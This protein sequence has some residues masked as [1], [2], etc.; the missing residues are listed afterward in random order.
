MPPDLKMFVYFFF[1]HPLKYHLVLDFRTN[2]HWHL[3]LNTHSIVGI[4]VGKILEKV[5][6]PFDV[7]KNISKLLKFNFSWICYQS[8]WFSCKN[9]WHLIFLKKLYQHLNQ[10]YLETTQIYLQKLSCLC[11]LSLFSPNAAHSSKMNSDHL[12]L[13]TPR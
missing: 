8:E 1:A 4:I 10:N 3:D 2:W 13:Q 9:R 5:V 6:S 12:L 11:C 7:M